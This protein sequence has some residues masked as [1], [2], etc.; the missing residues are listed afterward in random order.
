MATILHYF[1]DWYSGSV[2]GNLL[3][4]LL[5]VIPGYLW[6]RYHIKRVHKHLERH[7]KKLDAI[8]SSTNKDSS[9]ANPL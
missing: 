5:W 6:G 4:S 8:L 3:A 2:W 1:F 9:N 7:S